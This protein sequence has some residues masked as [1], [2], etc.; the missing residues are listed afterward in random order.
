MTGPD[1]ATQLSTTIA[2]LEATE[3]EYETTRISDDKSLKEAFHKAGQGVTLVK[4]ALK[5]AQAQ[6]N[7]NGPAMDPGSA[8]KSLERCDEKAKLSGDIFKAVAQAHGPRFDRYKAAVAL[9]G[10][11]IRVEDL[12]KGMMSDV[13]ALAQDGAIEAAIRDQ[14]EILSVAITTLTNM[15]P[16]LPDEHR[17]GTFLQ[18]GN[19]T[20]YNSTG[21]QNNNTGSGKQHIGG[22]YHGTVHF[23]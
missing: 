15:E 6:L 12:V 17:A 22:I 18:Y 13:C 20:Q 5:T 3:N 21:S 8:M 2:I 14:V 23:A 7:G 16:S 11:G 10:R 1:L 9:K 4:D 19:G